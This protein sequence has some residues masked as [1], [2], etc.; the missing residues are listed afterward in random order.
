VIVVLR[1]RALLRKPIWRTAHLQDQCTISSARHAPTDDRAIWRFIGS[2]DAGR[3]RNAV[4][5]VA[6]NNVLVQRVKTDSI[7][8]HVFDVEPNLDTG[9]GSNGVTFDNN[10]IGSYAENAYSIVEGAPTFNQSFTNNSVFGQGLKVAIADPAHAGYRP[11]NVTITGNFSDTPQ[12]PAAINVDHVDGLTIRG[13]HIP[14]TGG[15]MAAIVGSCD[16][17]ISGNSYSGGSTQALIYPSLCFFSPARGGPGSKVAVT[18]SGF[19]GTTAVTIGG[20]RASSTLHSGTRST[21]T[22]P[23]SARSGPITVRTP[24]GDA[25][26]PGD[27]TVTS[28]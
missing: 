19:N 26:S 15:P 20:R 25:V 1:S 10:T 8:Y 4:A 7:G 24:N 5:V 16:L 6:G 28:G 22:V 21:L 9:W 3:G 17:A 23:R 12:A 11:R 14:M 2:T 13:N 27:F 18:G